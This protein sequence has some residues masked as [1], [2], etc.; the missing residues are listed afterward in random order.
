VARHLHVRWLHHSLTSFD[1]Y[2][3]RSFHLQREGAFQKRA[4]RQPSIRRK[5]GLPSL[6]EMLRSR[7]AR[8]PLKSRR[9][10]TA[11]RRRSR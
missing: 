5:R 4:I 6:A 3:R 11:V 1:G 10:N 2:R 7:Y 9:L 8:R